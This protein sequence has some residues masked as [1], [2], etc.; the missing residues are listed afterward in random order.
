MTNTVT[1]TS[2][3]PASPADASPR[4]TSTPVA[5]WIVYALGLLAAFV[6][7]LSLAVVAIAWSTT[8]DGGFGLDVSFTAFVVWLAL[9]VAAAVTF[10]WRRFGASR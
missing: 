2:R 9:A 3:D 4:S 10:I 1:E 8:G 5:V 7:L 6:F